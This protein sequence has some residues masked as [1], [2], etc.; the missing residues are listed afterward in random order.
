M[1]HPCI[2][3]T[4]QLLGRPSGVADDQP[5]IARTFSY[6]RFEVIFLGGDVNPP[7]RFHFRQRQRAVNGDNRARQ[8]AAEVNQS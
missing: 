7:P 8:R 1:P 5:I 2:K 4:G 3:L 6:Q